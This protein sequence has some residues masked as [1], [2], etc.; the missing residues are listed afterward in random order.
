[1]GRV[2]KARDQMLQRNVAM[3][4]V[5][6]PPGLTGEALEELRVRSLREARA[7]ARLDHVNV[8]R[9]F[10]VLLGNGGD[11]WIVMEY[12]PSRS[13]HEIIIADGPISPV[14][15]AEIGL[16]VLGA[17][18]AAHRAGLMHRDVKP[19]NVLIGND[20][21]IV[22][23]D[24]GLATAVEDPNLTS[25]GVLLGSP[26]YVSPERAISGAVGAEGDLWS[27][28]ATLFAAVEGHAPYAR[29]SSLMSLTALVTEPPP[30]AEHA[31]PLAPVLEGL[32]CK[33][34]AQRIDADAAERLLR[35]VLREPLGDTS[36]AGGADTGT[37]AE[38]PAD[39]TARRIRTLRPRWRQLIGA[40]AALLVLGLT[41]GVL[42]VAREHPT[43]ISRA[44]DSPSADVRQSSFP[45]AAATEPAPLTWSVYQ[46]G[47]GFAV[48]APRDWQVARQGNEVDFREPGGDRLLVVSQ[49][50]APEPDPLA[51]L[52]A[53]EKTRATGGQYRGYRRIAITAVNYHL[54]A[55]DWE[56]TYTTGADHLIHVRQRTFVTAKQKG[57]T[58]AWSAPES[59]WAASADAFRR[60]TD[61]FRPAPN[62][63][64]A[65][66]QR[67]ATPPP[68]ATSPAKPSTAAGMPGFQL[69]G[70]ASGRCLD[71][72]NPDSPD[73]VR[74][75]IW[76]C[77]AGRARNQRWT[78]FPDG[79]IRLLGRCMDVLGAS[80]DN[81]AAIQLTTCNG[82]PAQHFTLNS[83]QQL[84][85]AHS[86]LCLDVTS[87]GTQNGALI[88]QFTC[89]N[90]A[91]NQK[92]TRN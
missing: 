21:R 26:A 90:G 87:T 8:V 59:A 60:I 86:R 31:G 6:P 92:W 10:D 2:W 36:R 33:D 41:A 54:S 78:F 63:S 47:S 9:V 62:P 82:T 80:S 84:V 7:I 57:Y 77:S 67:S 44:S 81:G 14:R 65:G 58:I 45:A 89:N 83:E 16:G 22:L 24:F 61:G 76:D 71:V 73:P 12:V 13:L 37:G 50:S 29:P 1:M 55:A 35:Q 70:K 18:Q 11:P 30:L 32:L 46:D 56:W 43:E 66:T 64:A 48:P 51:E 5:V 74:L 91:D 49:T 38:R 85:N 52:T 19:A 72:A 69:I 20:G 34:P 79:S 15:A 4:E 28:G 75:Q 27:L 53:R 25:S 88:Q 40:L 68:G 23:T 17:L 39:D 42:L 3:K